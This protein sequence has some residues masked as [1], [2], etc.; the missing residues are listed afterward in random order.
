M[1]EIISFRR[2]ILFIPSSADRQLG[3]FHNFPAINSAAV[4]TDEQVSLETNFEA[5][6]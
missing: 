5:L 2:N 3:G 1:T 4:D 6:G